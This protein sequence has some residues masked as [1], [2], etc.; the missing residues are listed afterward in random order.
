MTKS[1]DL[2]SVALKGQTFRPCNNNEPTLSSVANLKLAYQK[3]LPRLSECI[4]DSSILQVASSL[5]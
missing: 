3:N 5:A 2:L 4:I 1:R